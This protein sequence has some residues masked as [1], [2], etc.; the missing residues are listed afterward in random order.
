MY[1]KSE[2]SD[3]LIVTEEGGPC[4]AALNII[5]FGATTTDGNYIPLEEITPDKYLGMILDN[6]LSFNQHVDAI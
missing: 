6:K 5:K 3:R 1:V 4:K 2:E